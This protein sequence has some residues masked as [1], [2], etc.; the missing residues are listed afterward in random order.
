[1]PEHAKGH[2]E[3][4]RNS[5]IRQFAECRGGATAIV[6]AIALLPVMMAVGVAIDYSRA[7]DH[8]TALQKAADAAALAAATH[9]E[10]DFN[11]LKS[12]ADATFN[13]NF[14]TAKTVTV[15][16]KGLKQGTNGSLVYE[17][18]AT[19]S[20]SVGQVIGKK[21]QPVS[22][23]AEAS[24][25][26][27]AMGKGREIVFVID[28]TNSMGLWSCWS[29]VISSLRGWLDTAKVNS[30]ANDF[31]VTL[32][33]FSDR[34]NIGKSRTAWLSFNPGTSWNGCTEP[35]EETISGVKFTA[36]DKNPNAL[37]F[38]P[39]VAGQYV[40]NYS[41][42]K[43]HRPAPACPTQAIL[44]PTSD[45]QLLQTTL[46]N[47]KTDLGT[48]RF[49]DGLAWG[50][51]SLSP[52]WNNR[53]GISGYP[54]GFGKR[55]KTLVF[56]TDGFASIGHIEQGP[57]TSAV[58]AGNPNWGNILTQNQI[59]SFK[60]VCNSI[61]KEKVDLH[62]I[63][64]TTGQKAWKP[65]MQGCASTPSHYHEAWNDATLS[66]ALKKVVIGDS[67]PAK[68]ARIVK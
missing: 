23:L 67:S 31:F 32:I 30:G 47:I 29:C 1:M 62:M 33:P 37:K 59:D 61:K 9:T 24:R 13:I 51:R 20:M 3:P 58:V 18:K 54:A 38:R 35:R 52:N 7:A 21:T 17:A 11:K 16:S 12:Y 50:W 2:L 56:I 6:F 39:S 36:S 42:P 49:E 44:G 66:A 65:V 27:P 19:I 26:A 63:W 15:T 34:V 57:G 64:L 45:V 48:G 46:N 14:P 5:S 41:S 28:V 8:R 4:G 22:V 68:T 60:Q 25:F 53:W 40:G 55:D 10:S 43:A